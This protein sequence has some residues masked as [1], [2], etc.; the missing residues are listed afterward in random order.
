MELKKIKWFAGVAIIAVVGVVAFK[1]IDIK[2]VDE[3]KKEQ[4]QLAESG[5]QR[6]KEGRAQ[7]VFEDGDVV[8]EKEVNDAIKDQNENNT[9]QQGNEDNKDSFDKNKNTEEKEST[10]ESKKLNESESVDE[11]ESTNRDNNA[12]QKDT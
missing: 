5:V 2:S 1:N 10:S 9:S 6:D 8:S 7:I 4:Q 11:N 3:Y 12:G